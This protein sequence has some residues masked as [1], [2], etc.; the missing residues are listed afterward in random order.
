MTKRTD[1]DLRPGVP[2]TATRPRC[3]SCEQCGK[4][5][6]VALATRY[7]IMLDYTGAE[8]RERGTLYRSWGGG[9]IV[10]LST[11]DAGIDIVFMSGVWILV[12][13]NLGW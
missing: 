1:S 12:Y 6:R 13:C 5:T 3:S 9:E 11:T 2:A 4:K 10:G 7:G 8:S